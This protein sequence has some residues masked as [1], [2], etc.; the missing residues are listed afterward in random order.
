MAARPLEALG[1][2]GGDAQRQRALEQ[3][4]AAALLRCLEAPRV[5]SRALWKR[6]PPVGRVTA[7]SSCS[8]A[9]SPLGPPSTSCSSSFLCVL[10][11]SG[12]L[13]SG[14]Q[15]DGDSP[16]PASPLPE[17]QIR[18]FCRSSPWAAPDV[19]D[20]AGPSFPQTPPR[21]SPPSHLKWPHPAGAPARVLG[22]SPRQPCL[23][24][25]LCPAPTPPLS[26]DWPPAVAACSRAGGARRGARRARLLGL[27]QL[28]QRGLCRQPGWRAEPP[29]M[30]SLGERAIP[31]GQ[32]VRPLSCGPGHSRGR[33]AFAGPLAG[34]A[35]V[36]PG[37]FGAPGPPDTVPRVDA[38]CA[39]SCRLHRL[40]LRPSAARGHMG[41]CVSLV[42]FGCG[43]SASD[44]DR[45][46][47][48]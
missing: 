31:P 4:T 25:S 23:V 10:S 7:A 40:A 27:V 20:G 5:S 48:D 35:P 21:P 15:H 46:P 8:E 45:E 12:T 9:L 16:P 13:A 30:R 28:V 14:P 18:G 43:A 44:V 38:V 22:C 42:P 11:L 2:A 34:W 24:R 26:P 29:L 6:P 17:C 1:T 3:G 41:F 36:T 19:T 32:M 47:S 37:S 39:V 33:C